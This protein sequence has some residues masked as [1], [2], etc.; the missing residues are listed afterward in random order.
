MSRSA[1][2]ARVETEQALCA[3]CAYCAYCDYC[4]LPVASDEP[5]HVRLYCCY[6]CRVADSILGSDDADAEGSESDAA[7][8]LTRLGLAVFFSMNVMVLALAQWS[9][10]LYPDA[11][12]QS[13]RAQS[14]LE[15]LR[16]TS[17]LL[18]L[19]VF[20]LL[21]VSLAHNALQQLMRRRLTTDLLVV[22]G[23]VGALAYSVI[24]VF[25]GARHTYFEVACMVLVAMTLG[26][27]LEAT[28]KLKTTSSLR[29][30]QQLLP[31]EARRLVANAGD[32][33]EA[34]SGPATQKG[35]GLEGDGDA[36]TF[37]A[38]ATENVPLADV[39]VGD[40]LRVLPGE[41]LPVDGVI[42]QG[43]A[44]VDEM[45]MTGESRPVT[46]QPGDA[47]YAGARN[48]DGD[49]LIRVTAPPF[50]GALQRIVDAVV[51]AALQKSRIQTTADR[52]A[53]WMTPLVVALALAAFA[54]HGWNRGPA[55]GLM[56][57]LSVLLIACPC[58]LGVAT[59]LAVWAAMGR[60]SEAGVLFRSGDAIQQLSLADH[61]CFDKTGTLTTGAAIVDHWLIH[62]ENL[63]GSQAF[64][65]AAAAEASAEDHGSS[66]ANDLKTQLDAAGDEAWLA[67]RVAFTCA[68]ASNHLL[69]QAVLRL[70]EPAGAAPL[71]A[72]FSQNVAG[73]GVELE[74]EQLGLIRFG[75]LSWVG[76]STLSWRT[77]A[78]FYEEADD[79][80][81]SGCPTVAV[82]WQGAVRGLFVLT[83]EIRSESTRALA[84][85]S[86]QAGVTVL[87]GDNS[88]RAKMLAAEM[89]GGAAAPMD[90][91]DGLHPEQKQEAI[92]ELQRGGRTVAMVGDGINDAPAL[93]AADVG[94]AMGCGADVA[95]DS[96]DVCLLGDSLARLV[97]AS[98]LA[99]RSMRIVKQNLTW[100]FAYNGVG[101]IA[102][103][104]GQLNPIGAAAAMV[105]SSLLVISNSLRL[106]SHPLELRSGG[107]PGRSP[108]NATGSEPV[109]L[110]EPLAME[111]SGGARL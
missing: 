86:Q 33:G 19:V 1:P 58:A 64:H 23:V 88:S 37:A 67:A 26:R 56:T 79:A 16:A 10:A 25:T 53:A 22:M 84:D 77:P 76:D 71:P 75:R 43:R 60:A 63:S 2:A 102:A 61:F 106:S 85:L 65:A 44:A 108:A 91:R 39:V 13:A 70:L 34:R 81:K 30:L 52:V 95:R 100:A 55:E 15:L 96:A 36:E 18:S 50:G 109:A 73:D 46:R 107:A 90:V 14:L 111:I 68:S 12:L 3:Y 21:G 110:G 82:G 62:D 8:Q 54:W 20:L 27:W 42:L 51:Q 49:L 45:I 7:W 92:A 59:P 80:R 4:G 47:V 104:C 11:S 97:W 29:S 72:A 69:A 48:E 98:E 89:Q 99:Q 93:A 105:G 101:I 40:C 66:P 6:G 32:S 38:R 28:G 87:T 24:A 9:W 74:S 41:R 31:A 83:E 94:V 103:M 78:E 57:S 5:S 17:M 35:D